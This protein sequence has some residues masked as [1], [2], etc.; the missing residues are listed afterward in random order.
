MSRDLEV[1]GRPESCEARNGLP[2]AN[3][4][5]RSYY[6]SR[7]DGR[8]MLVVQR[9]AGESLGINGGITVDILE[10]QRDLVK[11]AIECLPDA[12]ANS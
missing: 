11:L 8:R 12:A 10:I 3:G 9:R 6:F 7:H 1:D 5:A 4:K 2:V